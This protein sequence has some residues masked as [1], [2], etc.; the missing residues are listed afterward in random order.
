MK[1]DYEKVSDTMDR[2]SDHI[3]TEFEKGLKELQEEQQKEK[4]NRRSWFIGIWVSLIIIMGMLLLI[5]YLL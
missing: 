2:C 3:L 1:S 5:V 4:R